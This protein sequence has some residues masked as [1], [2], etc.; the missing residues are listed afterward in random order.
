MARRRAR[1]PSVR[2]TAAVRPLGLL[3][4]LTTLALVI[5]HGATL[6]HMALV[7]HRTC[8]HGQLVEIGH[9]AAAAESADEDASREEGP[10]VRSGAEDEHKHCDVQALR[11]RPAEIQ[12]PLAE[13][14]LLR[15]EPPPSREG[16]IE[17]RP[18]PLLSL[19]PKSSPPTA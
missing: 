12:P 4:V 10:S 2:S 15:F 13:A 1:R 18:V 16:A 7:P 17:A 11:H 3:L 5:A 6:L 19:A 14:V 9:D 8:E